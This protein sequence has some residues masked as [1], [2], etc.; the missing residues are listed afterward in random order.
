MLWLPCSD[1]H[2]APV[3]FWFF[4]TPLALA[5]SF[6]YFQIFPVIMVGPLPKAHWNWSV[7]LLDRNALSSA[8]VNLLIVPWSAILG[9]LMLL[10]GSPLRQNLLEEVGYFRWSPTQSVLKPNMVGNVDH[11]LVFWL[12]L[13]CIENCTWKKKPIHKKENLKSTKLIGTGN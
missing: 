9:E 11:S 13:D 3:C 7:H 1:Q 10:V 2:R 6:D 5:I 4:S 12:S 8:S